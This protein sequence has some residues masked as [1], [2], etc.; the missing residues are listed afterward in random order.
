MGDR[1]GHALVS[2]GLALLAD[3]D[4]TELLLV[5]MIFNTSSRSL[6]GGS[7]PGCSSAL[8]TEGRVEAAR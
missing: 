8:A 7:I 6:T 4:T 1:G 2:L 5:A 3:P